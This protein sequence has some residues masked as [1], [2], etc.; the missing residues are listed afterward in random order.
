VLYA[1]TRREVLTKLRAASERADAGAPVRDA[2][3]TVAMWVA[4]WRCSTLEASARKDSTKSL[5]RSVCMKH[6]E[7]EPFGA[8]RLD[9]LRATEIETFIV[10]LRRDRKLAESTVRT[11]YTVLRGALDGA[12]RDGLIARNPAAVVKRP[13]LS[14]TEARCLNPAEV[15]LLLNELKASR[16]YPAIAVIASSGLRKVEALALT[17]DDVDLDAGTLRVRATLGRFDR[18]I[19]ISS[20]KSAKSRRVIR[21]SPR[22]VTLLRAHR[23][24][25]NAERIRAANVW[26]ESGFV[27]TTETG[28]P[29]D[30]R[31]LLRVLQNAAARLGLSDVSVHTLRHSAATA[32]LEAGIGIKTVSDQ[33]GHASV[34]ITGDIYQHVSDHAA[35][36]AADAL[37]DAIGI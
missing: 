37:A 1:R 3:A 15:S 23:K 2:K 19:V 16:F 32:L 25:Q 4:Q 28:Q 14:R 35:Q 11:I 31:N 33:L 5:Y 7:P 10:S 17:W 24:N 9:P 29:I 34:A 6:I 12:V 36:A 18:S 21:L 13:G 27:F 20:P 30:P 26:H 8:T 22:V